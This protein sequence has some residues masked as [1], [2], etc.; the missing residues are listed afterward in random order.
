M[1]NA[2]KE[3]VG[4]PLWGYKNTEENSPPGLLLIS[5]VSTGK[6]REGGRK[7]KGREKIERNT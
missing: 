6:G 2:K 5:K 3:T 1:L 7:E 4:M